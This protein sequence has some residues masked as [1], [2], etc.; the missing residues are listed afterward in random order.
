MN[1]EIIANIEDEEV[2]IGITTKEY[3]PRIGETIWILPY[4]WE[5]EKEFGTRAFLVEDICHHV[6]LERSN[7]DSVVIYVTPILPDQ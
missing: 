2:P 7:Y 1:V 4:N 5:R 3:T 6:S